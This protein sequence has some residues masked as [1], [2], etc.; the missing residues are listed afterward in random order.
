[1]IVNN[2]LKLLNAKIK[3]WMVVI[4]Y[5]T[6]ATYYHTQLS[7]TVYSEWL[8]HTYESILVIL[9]SLYIYK[10]KPDNTIL[11][12]ILTIIYYKIVKLIMLTLGIYM[13]NGCIDRLYDYTLS[14][15]PSILISF[16]LVFLSLII[17]HV[18]CQSND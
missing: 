17:R 4:G 10:L 12:S 7:C 9:L 11:I 8:Y 18:I 13:S 3:L 6:I 15:I 16:I 14:Y 5:F 1:M 2:L